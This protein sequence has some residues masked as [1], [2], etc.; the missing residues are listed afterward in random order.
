[1]QKTSP[2]RF[3][4]QKV[5]PLEYDDS[6][7][8]YQLL[9]KVVSKLNNVID[10]TNGMIDAFQQLQEFIENYFKNLDVQ[11]EINKKLDQM[12]EEGFFSEIAKYFL[13]PSTL[14]FQ[15]MRNVA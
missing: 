13:I 12:A 3:W 15:Q 5:L 9:C 11:E 1:M 10:N 7:S 6:L 2:F 4:C 8:I 14:N